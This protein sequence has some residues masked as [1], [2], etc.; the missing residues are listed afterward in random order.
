MN[1]VR[2]HNIT[3]IRCPTVLPLSAVAAQQG[4]PSLAL[5]YLSGFLKSKDIP[6]HCL[7][8]LGEG[9]DQYFKVPGTNLIA[10]G[11]QASE[12]AERIPASSSIVGI[13]CMF[14]NEW[15]YTKEIVKA[16]SLRRPDLKIILGGEHATADYQ[17]IL[18]EC[19]EIYCC[20]LGE[21]E[22]I[23]HELV[24]TIHQ[25]DHRLQ[26]E[27]I[28]FLK[29][30]SNLVVNE[31]K[32]RIR[33][34]DEIPWPNWEGLCLEKYLDRGLGMA[35]QGRRSL[36]VL[37]SRG[38]PY[39]CTFCSSEK[40]WT[41]AWY[42]RDIDDLIQEIK[43]YTEKYHIQNV[44]F[45]DLTAIVNKKWIQD[46]CRALIKANLPITWTLPSGTRS[47]ALCPD[48][49]KL[50]RQSGC[51]KITYA[52]ESGSNHVLE[53]IKKKVNLPKMLSSMR[54][55]V[56]EG[57]IIK[58]NIVF[59]FPGSGFKD[60]FLDFFFLLKM[61]VI[62]VQDV[63]C[64]AFVPYPGSQLYEDLVSSGHIKRD[65]EYQKFL[66]YN[67]YNDP[68]KMRSWTKG[69][70]DWH[71]TY[72]TLGGMTFFYSFQFLFRPWRI[73][74]TM[75]RIIRRKPFTMFELAIDNIINSF[76]KGNKINI[77]E[78]QKTEKIANAA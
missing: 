62:G 10:N 15:I 19:P 3:L 41:T 77:S 42:P 14:S 71:L 27:G 31:R 66:S 40:M 61:A 49:L 25:S 43:T 16:I 58:A 67:V 11:L 47:E 35:A 59:G 39:R 21:G 52:P 7:D 72:L 5:A 1:N 2:E 76:F 78:E 73:I 28:A 29:D 46:F 56:K 32:K 22:A 20:V 64:F 26:T 38:C 68:T 44:E 48:T 50:L 55:A 4:V 6:C 65:N 69:L 54:A 51:L 74:T 17:Q 12:I 63:T 30:E 18:Q 24:S 8:A 13:S 57:M 53:M 33:N 34:I 37:A 36:P 75:A 45:Y 9:L 23:L 60:Y 70:K